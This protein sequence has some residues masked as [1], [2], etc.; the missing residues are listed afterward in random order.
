MPVRLADKAAL[1]IAP[2]FSAAITGQTD[3]S[4]GGTE[5]PV[6]PT[7]AG[8]SPYP[9]VTARTDTLGYRR[10]RA[11]HSANQSD[12]HGFIRPA[13]IL[14]DER[15]HLL[16]PPNRWLALARLSSAPPELDSIAWNRPPLAPDIC[17]RI[18]SLLRHAPNCRLTAARLLSVAA[19][20]GS[21]GVHPLRPSPNRWLTPAR[22]PSVAPELDSIAR[23]RPPFA[24]DSCR[25][26]RSLPWHPS[27][28]RPSPA[29]L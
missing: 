16:H 11:P 4:P 26:V 14:T 1:K 29:R 15:R 19:R 9:T 18:R 28:R 17:R 12:R 10:L 7:V 6:L 2:R 3:R 21:M 20:S 23:S 22:L 13:R 24:P 25:R 27:N 8:L 5:E